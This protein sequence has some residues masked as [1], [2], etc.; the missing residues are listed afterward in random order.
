[1]GKRR[2][3]V[4]V[5]LVIASVAVPAVARAGQSAQARLAAAYSP[6]VALEPQQQACGSGEPYRPTSVS[7]VL[8]K[9]G[10]TLRGPAGN[11]VKNAPTVADLFGR[12]E[13]YYL[14]LP[15]DPL[16]PGCTYETEF[17]RWNRGRPPVVY[18]HVAGDPAHPDRLAVQYWLFY[19]FNDFT[20]K[21]EGDWEMAQVDF[22]ARTPEQALRDGPYEVDVAQHAGGERAAWN[23]KKLAKQGD[24]PVIYA[25]TGSHAS[26]FGRA[27]YLGRSASAGF[28]CD[29]TRK[30]T[31]RIEPQVKILAGIPT[32]ASSREAWLGFWGRWGQKERG[33]DNG[34]TGPAAKDAWSFPIGWADGLRATSVRVPG[35]RTLGPSVTGFFCGAVGRV[36]VTL[37]RAAI[38]PWLFLAV[39]A[40]IAT[41]LV[42]AVHRTSWRPPDPR[43]VRMSRRGG[44][45]LRA[46]G[47]LYR[48]NWPMFVAVGVIFI[49]ISLAAM[50]AQWLLFHLTPIGA[51]VALDGRRG[52]ITTVLAL[53]IGNVGATCAS[54]IT[55]AAV[56]AALS[57]LD[58]GRNIG[59]KEA[60]RAAFRH[61]RALAGGFIRQLGMLLLL[62]ITVIGIPFAIHRFIR[63]SLFTQTC[64]LEERSARESLRSSSELVRGR[65]WRSFGFTALVDIL[66]IVSGPVL[67]VAL[68]LLTDRSLDFINVAGSVVHTLTVPYAAIALTLYYFELVAT[69]QTGK[70]RRSRRRRR[71]MTGA[72]GTAAGGW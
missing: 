1:M 9:E 38:H 26:Y 58:A 3:L 16:R 15:G 34:P 72:G 51:F 48:G 18:A 30:A 28:G 42:A 20:D 13:G 69:R 12:G 50:A 64:V 71:T 59:G 41:A 45:I 8:G 62:T 68:L 4:G 29:D 6:V 25:A 22:R 33:I 44:Q 11:V 46:S 40:V 2:V 24:H 27:L 37:T 39:L 55:T 54:V 17:K 35:T 21:H 32:S 23:A 57:E 65:W 7:T 66:V 36:S 67:G 70:R 61:L 60:Y 19:V 47:R 63:W 43:P 52:A 10:V 49:P 53:L 14:D 31:T 5:M 56:A